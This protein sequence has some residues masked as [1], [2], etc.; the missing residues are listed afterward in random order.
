[1][2]REEHNKQQLV[3]L[4]ATRVEPEEEHE[5]EKVEDPIRKDRRDD[6]PSRRS[7]L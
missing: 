6:V 2:R 3:Q 4:V 1:V 7:D 5:R